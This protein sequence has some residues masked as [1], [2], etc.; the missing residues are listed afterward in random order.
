MD[1]TRNNFKFDLFCNSRFNSATNNMITR[2]QNTF[3]SAINKHISLPR[4]IT[5]VLDDDLITYL[6]YKGVGGELLGA[7]LSWLIKEL[8]QLLST[9]KTQ[10]PIKALRDCDPCTYW[11]VAPTHSNFSKQRNDIRKK[12]NFCLESTLK[13][14]QDMR[15]LKLKE[16]D[17]ND[18]AL[19][20]ADKITDYGLYT[21]WNCIDAAF[22]F[23]AKKHKL[24]V[25]KM[26]LNAQAKPKA[27]MDKNPLARDDIGHRYKDDGSNESSVEEVSCRRH[28]DVPT[29]F[30]RHS[31]FNTRDRFHW[32]HSDN[33]RSRHGDHF[34]L[35]RPRR[36]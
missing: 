32:H 27:V 12:L 2:I 20:K 8:E 14:K 17:Y 3:A 13:G 33:H 21:Y 24:Y 10:L 29:F 16:W 28:D 7:W 9:R 36:F 31:S 23:N 5:V 22:Q 30:R 25:V 34:L 1:Y 4:Y 19:V 18:A 11:C 6:D 26:L 15:I 35:P